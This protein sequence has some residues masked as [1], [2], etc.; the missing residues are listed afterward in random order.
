M[1][2]GGLQINLDYLSY[3]CS[4]ARMFVIVLVSDVHI[5]FCSQQLKPGMESR[6]L[7]LF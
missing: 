1:F 5:T 4:L 7:C 6:G 2:L 3:T